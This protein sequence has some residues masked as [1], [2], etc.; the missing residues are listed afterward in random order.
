MEI[1]KTF[2]RAEQF[3]CDKYEVDVVIRGTPSDPLFC[4]SQIS[5]IFGLAF[6]PSTC[7]LK[8]S[9]KVFLTH[10]GKENVCF[11]TETGMHKFLLSQ[12]NHSVVFD[13]QSWICNVIK[14]IRM[15]EPKEQLK[16]EHSEDNKEFTRNVKQRL[17]NFEK[18]VETIADQ[19]SEFISNECDDGGYIA[20]LDHSKTEIL[21]VYLNVKFAAFQN[22]YLNPLDLDYAVQTDTMSRGYYYCTYASVPDILRQLFEAE[23]GK[24][25]LFKNGIVQLDRDKEIVQEFASKIDCM[26]EMALN[27]KTL[28]KALSDGL[29]CNGFIYEELSERLAWL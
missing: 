11:V 5:G 9:E 4:A 2:F 29:P 17:D 26:R 12:T 8:D 16:C 20:K 13:F 24:P 1:V 25:L 14:E 10:N 21:N 28:Q 22:G 3:N 6:I 23:H 19:I 18:K 7:K 15:G 27:E